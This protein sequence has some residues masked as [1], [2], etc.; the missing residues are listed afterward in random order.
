MTGLLV[1]AVAPAGIL[2]AADLRAPELPAGLALIASG[3]LAAV[4]GE[5]PAGGLGGQ[6]RSA[7]LPWLLARQRLLE[8]LL[9]RGPVLPVALGTVVETPERVR[10][11]LEAGAPE[12][13]SAL[14]ALGDRRELNLSVRWPIE[15]VV[16]G[17][18]AALPA[19]L[20]AA[21]APERDDAEARRDLGAALAKG[22]EQE[23]LRVRRS[24]TERLRALAHDMILSEPLE[25]EGV[26]NLAL[27]LDAAA[28]KALDVALEDL[29]RSFEGRLTF[30][31]VGPLPPYSFASV[32]VNLATADTVAESRAILG[33][34]VGEGRQALKSAYRSALRGAHPDLVASGHENGELA[35][36]EAAR[37]MALTAAYRVLEAEYAPV[38]LLRQ[39]SLVLS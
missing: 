32:K 14:Q 39:D 20:R 15:A 16:A 2:G 18:L 4:L 6:D 13:S 5:A 7:L 12:L 23:K 33:I 10:H 38:S 11:L 35:P 21:A 31:L 36:A 17:Q 22:V 34:P 28:E 25:P 27:L 3:G 30:R 1:F 8:H 9:A 37:V 24:V 26:L 29:D 19:E